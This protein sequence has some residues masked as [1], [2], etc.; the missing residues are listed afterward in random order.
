MPASGPF[1]PNEAIEPEMAE[2]R[3]RAVT[4]EPNA[5]SGS[6]GDAAAKIAALEIGLGTGD[7]Q[8]A[9]EIEMDL[10]AAAPQP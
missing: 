3:G 4:A 2:G 1:S 8:F 9:L 7:K 6:T 10:A 5:L